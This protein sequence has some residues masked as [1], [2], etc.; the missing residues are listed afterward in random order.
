MKKFKVKTKKLAIDSKIGL[1]IFQIDVYEMKANSITDCLSRF[2]NE[3]EIVSIEVS[4]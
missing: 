1:P 2:E 3:N 4:E